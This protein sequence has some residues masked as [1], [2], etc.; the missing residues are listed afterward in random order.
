MTVSKQEIYDLFKSDCASVL[1]RS[2]GSHHES[3]IKQLEFVPSGKLTPAQSSLRMVGKGAG[4]IN[5]DHD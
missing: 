3:R 2:F 5:Y 4:V 1:N